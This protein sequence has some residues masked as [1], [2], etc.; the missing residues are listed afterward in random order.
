M[1]KQQKLLNLKKEAVMPKA[2]YKNM[3]EC[4]ADYKG[5]KGAKSICK[6]KVVGDDKMM[7]GGMKKDKKMMGGMMKKKKMGGYGS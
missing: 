2:K 7:M 5:F 6:S 1:Q 3:N 4:L